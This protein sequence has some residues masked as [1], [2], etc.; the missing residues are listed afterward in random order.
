MSR[1][2]LPEFDR[3]PTVA[4]GIRRSTIV[5]IGFCGGAPQS[6]VVGTTDVA[7]QC[8][9]DVRALHDSHTN[10]SIPPVR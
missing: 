3:P 1:V 8:A 10:Q 7:V 9:V 4:N 5:A 6:F 2:I